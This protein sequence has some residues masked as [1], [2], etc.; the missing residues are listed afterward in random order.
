MDEA[1]ANIDEKTDSIIQK[2]I[3][4][5]LKGTTV[6]TIA[7][8]LNTI[9]NYD[10]ILVMENGTLKESGS[11]KELLSHNDGDFRAMVKDGGEEFFEKMVQI[12]NV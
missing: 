8:R 9:M 3:L 11:P 2:V 6:I 7:H 5:K 12:A 10:R 1:T 4:K